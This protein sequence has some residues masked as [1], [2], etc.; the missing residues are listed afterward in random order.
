MIQEYTFHSKCMTKTCYNKMNS[1][2]TNRSRGKKHVCQ[3]LRTACLL[4]AMPLLKKTQVCPSMLLMRTQFWVME[5]ME[6]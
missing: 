1:S 6:S 3:D 5:T 2:F 4:C